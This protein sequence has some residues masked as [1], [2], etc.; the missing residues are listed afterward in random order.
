MSGEAMKKEY[1]DGGGRACTL[2]AAGSG[3]GAARP[4][5]RLTSLLA[6]GVV[7]AGTMAAAVTFPLSSAGAAGPAPV[8]VTPFSGFDPS[9]TRAPYV[10]DLT[11]VSAAVSWA[12]NAVAVGTLRWGPAGNCT[13]N[14]ATVPSVLPT[15]VPASG[16]P[17]SA[18]G[19]QFTVN[20]TSEFQSTVILTGLSPN[21]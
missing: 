5:R 16:S 20:S 13:A 10:T 12:T 15:L 9:L 7:V 8:A 19:R 18:T 6:A 14:Q 4:R 2:D 17:A 1:S 21:T 3:R 11:Q